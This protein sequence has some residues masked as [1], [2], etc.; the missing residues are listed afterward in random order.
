VNPL[1]LGPSNVSHGNWTVPPPSTI[2]SETIAVFGAHCHVSLKGMVSYS[3][4]GQTV[5]VLEWASHLFGAPSI[6]V[7]DS[8]AFSV[9]VKTTPG[10]HLSVEVSIKTKDVTGPLSLEL[11]AHLCAESYF[12]KEEISA[13]YDQFVELAA[14]GNVLTKD[15]VR[16]HFPVLAQSEVVLNSVFSAFDEAHTK[17]NLIDFEEYVKV[18]SIMCRGQYD[19][20]LALAFRICDLN[21][22]GSVEKEE[23]LEICG[24]VAKAVERAG[25]GPENYGDP[26]EI[27]ENLFSRIAPDQPDMTVLT[28]EEFLLRGRDEPDFA[29][30]FGFF[31]FCYCKL[32]KPIEAKIQGQTLPSLQGYVEVERDGKLKKLL[33]TRKKWYFD[34]QNGFVAVKKHSEDADPARVI[35]LHG[36]LINSETSFLRLYNAAR[37]R[38]IFFADEDV[39]RSF[40]H[41]LRQNAAADFRFRSFAPLRNHINVEY[42]I[43]GDEYFNKLIPALLSAEKRV[44]I[45]DWWLCPGLLLSRKY[46]FDEDMRLDRLLQKKAK[47]GVKIYII[48]WN[49]LPVPFQLK[50][51]IVCNE[52]N[53]IHKN[54]LCLRHPPASATFRWTHH[55]KFVVIDER[56]AF[57]GGLDLCYGR[58]EDSRYLITDPES[59]VYPGRDYNNFC[60][61]GESYGDPLAPCIDRNLL[62]R[63]P[64]HDIMVQIDGAAAKDIGINFI[65]RWNYIMDK[66]HRKPFLRPFTSQE[67]KE[68]EFKRRREASATYQNLNCQVLRSI[69]TWSA[70]T[71][72]PERSIY[73]AYLAA[74]N[75]AQHYIYIEN[76]YFISSIDTTAPKNRILKALYNRLHKAI[77]GNE[78]FKVIVLLPAYP[79]GILNDAATVYLIKYHFKA[80][81]REGNSILEKLASDFPGV[82]LSEYISFHCLRNW[83]ELGGQT[84]T[85]HIYIHTKICIVD[86]RIAIVGS[87]NIN[88]RS[89]R[90]THDSEIAVIIEQAGLVDSVMAGKP[91]Q[92]SPFA[93]DFRMRLWRDFLGLDQSDV[94]ITDAVC[95]AVHNLWKQTSRQNT[96]VYKHVFQILPDTT[97]T[98]AQVNIAKPAETR[99][100]QRLREVRGYLVDYPLDLFRDESMA[101]PLASKERLVPTSIYL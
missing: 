25:F 50:S 100:V 90:G 40:I 66:T 84:V 45:S 49:A 60:Y 44:F 15:N 101:L 96:E 87:A 79:S 57:V 53:K 39:K 69:C 33:H 76:Q 12:D 2:P 52:L 68:I 38:R 86:D 24:L 51:N 21:G 8:D 18:L 70:G 83:G 75:G 80:I 71:A 23:A 28:R 27:V 55:Q 16:H 20:K 72:V 37:S 41:V 36:M 10:K 77:Q 46:P 99:D 22:D 88:D 7:Q 31:T 47:E 63:M 62:P 6:K 34:I 91:F 13:L 67:D 74:I 30:A 4:R 59:K 3:N 95:P 65:Q 54:V 26:V 11:L 92:V 1:I 81:S 78:T 61:Q 89:M 14:P 17:D 42:L 5:L 97:Y 9:V 64:W 58:Y 56:L 19:E 32:V 98:L 85:T 94:S 73:K 82:D 48:I 35:S 43:N 29:D 93:R